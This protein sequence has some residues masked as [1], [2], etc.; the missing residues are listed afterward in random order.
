MRTPLPAV[1]ATAA[2][3]GL[4]WIDPLY[5]PIITLGPLVTGVAMGLAGAAPRAVALVW[6][7]A[8]IAVLV[9]DLAINQEDVAFHAAVACVAA[10]L[11]AGSAWVGRRMRTRP[12]AA[13]PA[14]R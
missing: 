3:V 13:V 12:G 1:L 2:I 6:F 8:G 11:A 5:L 10:A 4:A 7:A 14:E 9:L